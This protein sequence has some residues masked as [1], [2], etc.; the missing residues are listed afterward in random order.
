MTWLPME[1]AD[2]YRVYRSTEREGT[3]EDVSGLISR[4]NYKDK[5]LVPG[6]MYFYKIAPSIEGSIMS[7]PKYASPNGMKLRPEILASVSV[8]M[9]NETG[10]SDS[11][12]ELAVVGNYAYGLLQYGGL[13]VYDISSPSNPRQ[14]FTD[15]YTIGGQHYYTYG[16]ITVYDGYLYISCCSSGISN[17]PDKLLVY[18]LVNTGEP[19]LV[20]V[21]NTNIDFY[22][23]DFIP[24]NDYLYIG[25]VLNT[26]TAG[27]QVLDISSP[28]DMTFAS[29]LTEN[30]LNLTT[31]RIEGMTVHNGELY[32]S[33]RNYYSGTYLY[34]YDITTPTKTTLLGSSSGLPASFCGGVYVEGDEGAETAYILGGNRRFQVLDASNPSS[35]SETASYNVITDP[36]ALTI[37]N[38]YAYI[39]YGSGTLQYIGLNGS[40]D[41]DNGVFT[42]SDGRIM[43]TNGTAQDIVYS[44]GYLWVADGPGGLTVVEPAS[45]GT[46]SA[47]NEIDLYAAKRMTVDGEYAYIAEGLEGV[48]GFVHIGFG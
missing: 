30:D 35:I 31:L 6:E 47:G 17:G 24:Y 3:Y 32:I 25:S 27:I 13:V 23:Y 18:S 48:R 22:I 33:N 40:R 28:E 38:G 21:L 4:T 14:V 10:A 43:V 20:N 5:N 1:G 8:P 29:N 11:L 44:G 45:F 9:A 36:Q 19:E 7:E 16:K 34:I 26:N 15:R 12:L 41:D 2:S 39:T 46:L 42:I 37:Y